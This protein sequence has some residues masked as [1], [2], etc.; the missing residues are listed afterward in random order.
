MNTQ[1]GQ[2]DGPTR[3]PNWSRINQWLPWLGLAGAVGWLV[4]GHGA[5]LLG[6]APFL[7][8]LACLRMHFF[9]HRGH[10]GHS[11]HAPDDEP[12]PPKR[13]EEPTEGSGGHVH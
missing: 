4:Y 12:A 2:H 10:G 5:H 11:G 7:I 3:S 9:G 6:I 1:H 13:D 8:L